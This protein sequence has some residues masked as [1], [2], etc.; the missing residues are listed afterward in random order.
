MLK[1]FHTKKQQIARKET[2]NEKSLKLRS[3]HKG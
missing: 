2:R 1:V 3:T